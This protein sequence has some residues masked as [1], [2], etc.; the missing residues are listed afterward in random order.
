MTKLLLSALLI[1][2]ESF[3]FGKKEKVCLFVQDPTEQFFHNAENREPTTT[4]RSLCV[5]V[6]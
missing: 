1:N 5:S 6:V 3:V 4:K 2:A